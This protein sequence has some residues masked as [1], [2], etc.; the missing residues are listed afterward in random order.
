[1]TPGV[2]ARAARTG[3]AG[4]TGRMDVNSSLPGRVSVSQLELMLRKPWADVTRA[5]TIAT[6]TIR[7]PAARVVRLRSRDS[8]LRASLSAFRK[9]RKGSPASSTRA[10]S[11]RG[12][13][14]TTTSRSP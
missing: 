4:S 14:S 7:A 10:P 3:S 13:S 12:T 9:A 11:S 5:I 6:P 2:A 8:E 1:M